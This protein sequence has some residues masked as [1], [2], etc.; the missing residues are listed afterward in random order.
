[1][2]NTTIFANAQG[3]T[4]GPHADFRTVAG[5]AITNHISYQCTHAEDRVVVHGKTYRRI[6][7]GDIVFRGQH[8]SKVIAVTIKSEGGASTLLASR[9]VKVRKMTRTAEVVGFGGRFTVT[10]FESADEN[11]DG[12]DS[13]VLKCVLNAATARRSPFLPQLFAFSGSNL[14]TFIAHGELTSGDIFAAQFQ[15][16]NWIAYYYLQYTL[17]VVMNSLRDDETVSFPIA[18]RWRY[19]LLDLKTLSWHFDPA[20][21]A[22]DPPR[23]ENLL[24]FPNDSPPLRQDT[25]RQLNTAEIVA[26]VEDTLGDVL[27]LVAPFER[28]WSGDLSGWDKHG[29]F[30]F[31]T[32]VDRNRAGILAHFP[33]TPSLE[34]FCQSGHPDVKARFS[35]SVPWRADLS[36]RKTGDVRVT[37]NFGWRIPKKNRNRL[38]AAYLCQSIPFLNGHENVEQVI[39][40]DQVGFE[41]TATFNHDPTTSSTPAYLFVP[42]LPVDLINNMQCVQYPFPKSNPSPFYWSCDPQDEQIIAEEKWDEFGIPKLE[43]KDSVGSCWES[44]HYDFVREHLTSSSKYN[45]DKTRQYA[46]EH[47]Y[48]ELIY[49]DPHEVPFVQDFDSES[50][51]HTTMERPS[52]TFVVDGSGGSIT[53][54]L[55]DFELVDEVEAESQHELEAL[56]NP[57]VPRSTSLFGWTRFIETIGKTSHQQKWRG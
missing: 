33:S 28:R 30:T 20:S 32:I 7:D 29:F 2:S 21:V 41:L 26:S 3:T 37:L 6:I 4:I 45:L 9:A 12:F 44:Q 39:Y 47:G 22:L 18:N 14:S 34:W 54:D 56:N 42:P 43:M 15:G 51:I 13:Q 49:A 38:R 35:S 8:S 48:P 50:G 11:D 31:G 10:T 23:E 16:N 19:W 25:V 36:F 46:R 53:E 17:W 1:M 5:D 27:C 24:P 57:N 55:N 52:A 40:I